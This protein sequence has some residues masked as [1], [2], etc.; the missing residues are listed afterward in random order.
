V[1]RATR[2][3]ITAAVAGGAL[4]L[5][6]AA[7]R[8]PAFA[9]V[10]ITQ[11]VVAVT[12]G[13]LV[14]GSWVWPLV[15]FRGGE[16]E[17]FHLDE[18]FLVILALL[19]PPLLT[20]GTLATATILAQAARRR[21]WAKSAFNSGQLLISAGVALAVSR[22]IAA[23]GD[24]ILTAQIAAVL[25]GVVSYLSVN[26]L[27]VSGAMV[28]MGASWKDFTE[29]LPIRVSLAGAGALTGV[30]LALAIQAQL[31]AVLLAIPGL[32]LERRLISARF[33]AL[34]DRT[35]IAGLYEVT[36]EANRGL[37]QQA[38]LDS[39]LGAVRI[40]LRSPQA[41]LTAGPP[42]P[43]QLAATMT[44]AGQQQWLVASGRRRDE[45]FD[46]ADE[47]LLRALAA[48]GSGALSNAEL[49]QQ[50]HLERERLAS[51]TL[52]IGEGVCAI[53]AD[54]KLTFVNPAAAEML[55][56]SEQD[57]A[58]GQHDR[59]AA[60]AAP[61]YLL[62][63]A[64][65]AIRTGATIREDDAV[66]RGRNGSTI[67]VAYTASAVLSN[68]RPSGA[69][70]AFRNITER[71]AFE[72]ELH[73]HAFYDSLT[74]LANRR[75]L[76]EHLD[77]ALHRSAQD[78]QTH[79]L[80]FV[81]VDRFKSI[82]DS[83]GHVTGDEF[84]VAI[85]DR[86][87]GVV[88]GRDLLARFGGD[89][90]VL[91]LRD[92]AGV[93]EA[94]VAAQRICTTVERPMVLPNGYEM[95][96][97]VSVGI[98]LTEA[99]AT[100]D[101]VLRDADVAMYEA[102]TR[103]GGGV[104]RVF[105]Q[106]SMG[107]RSS[108][109]LQIE[110]DLRKGLERHELDV[111]YQPLYSLDGQRIVGAEA[112]VRWRHPVNGLISPMNFIPMAEETGLILPLGQYV[113]EQAC[114]QVRSIRDRLHVDLPI[115]V[116]LSPRQFQEKGLLSQVAAALEADGLSS[117]SLMFEITESMVM[118]DLSGAREVMKKLNRL[119]VRLAIDD[120]GT[121][122]SSLAY[123]K[124]F[125]VHEVKVDRV[126][127][128]G[129]AHDPVDSAI[130]RAIIDLAQAMGIDAVAEGVETL[131]QV[132]ELQELGCPVAQGFYFSQP[133]AAGDFDALLA[134]HFGPVPARCRALRS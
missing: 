108:E 38:V 34:H 85:A 73:H 101:D 94:V 86:L 78:G 79:A 9:H 76:V 105:D 132:S 55:E 99:D 75:L 23:P 127:V 49:Y 30:V 134:T 126:F 62:V 117:D 39:I 114:H 25:L 1:P 87:K 72:D 96:A 35:R 41:A 121:G 19:V 104:Y 22:A 118:Q 115:S 131:A 64:L 2:I 82:N 128:Q 59:D 81:D 97:T 47:G 83:L 77:Q 51:I 69:V 100:A 67:P 29:D 129:I 46:D 92:V 48:V 61:G 26:S 8:Q 103:G 10:G 107:T 56:L 15:V 133:L 111:H 120:F 17:A 12:M 95:V 31:S 110:A 24:P 11:W 52:N 88:C 44:V 130:V 80:I 28:T 50:V 54:G 14:F 20:L 68:E 66:F 106:A 18:G 43:G 42:A 90:F 98:A 116:N 70:V 37:R 45:P 65:E 16:S 4:S 53:D 91:L 13:V 71:K 60:Q 102:K 63:P 6:A 123:L 40:L 124:Q 84:L 93:A 125:P 57:V 112:L 33:A 7:W 36:L 32:V 58:A 21:A 113:L 109:R 74:G 5:L 122:H 89:E 119:G 3:F 27:L